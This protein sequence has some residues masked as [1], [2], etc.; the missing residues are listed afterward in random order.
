MPHSGHL[1][2]KLCRSETGLK[3]F[4]SYKSNTRLLT[5]YLNPILGCIYYYIVTDIYLKIISII[6]FK[7]I[8]EYI[9]YIKNK[10]IGK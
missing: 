10:S 4:A 9:V 3:H 1:K 8:S 2:I 6:Y 7:H 5:L